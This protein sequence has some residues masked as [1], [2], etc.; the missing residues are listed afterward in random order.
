MAPPSI[1]LSLAQTPTSWGM[2][3]REPHGDG[4]QNMQDFWMAE[5]IV[6]HEYG[7]P[8]LSG[9]HHELSYRKLHDQ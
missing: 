5:S 2:N 6:R 7:F 8:E 3:L 4:R 1:W 9:L